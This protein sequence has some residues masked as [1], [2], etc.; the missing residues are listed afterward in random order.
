VGAVEKGAV[1]ADQSEQLPSQPSEEYLEAVG[2]GARD[3]VRLDR[4][5]MAR[6]A[7]REKANQWIRAHAVS[8]QPTRA[9]VDAWAQAN[10]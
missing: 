4:V 2:I 1:V 10:R 8:V 3:P 5:A 6:H 7:W 9:D